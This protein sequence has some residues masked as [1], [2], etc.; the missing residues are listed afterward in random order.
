M[1]VGFL[2]NEKIIQG[3]E[4][5]ESIHLSKSNCIEVWLN[6]PFSPPDRFIVTA[7]CGGGIT[8]TRRRT[9]V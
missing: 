4:D 2:F 1:A 3:T 8:T 9:S 5:I 6:I 7:G